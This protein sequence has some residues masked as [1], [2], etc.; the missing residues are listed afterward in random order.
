MSMW[1]ELITA[2]KYYGPLACISCRTCGPMVWIMFRP[3]MRPRNCGVRGSPP[4]SQADF[5]Y[6]DRLEAECTIL[7]MK[8]CTVCKQSKPKSE[9]K[10][11]SGHSDGLQ[12]QCVSCQRK[13]RRAHYLRN[14]QKYIRKAGEATARFMAR[15]A[16]YKSTLCCENCEEHDAACLDFHHTGEK[17]GTISALVRRGNIDKLC[18]ELSVCIPLCANCHRKLHAYG[19]LPNV[20]SARLRHGK[21]KYGMTFRAYLDAAEYVRPGPKVNRI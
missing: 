6:V 10:R 18:S 17:D 3:W 1:I 20:S 9:F 5:N 11:H 7:C 13:Y 12:S 2:S 16:G 21:Y 14:K 8:T 15:F 19:R 4:D